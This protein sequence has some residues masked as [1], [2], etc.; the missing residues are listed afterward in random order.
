MENHIVNMENRNRTTIT[1][2]SDVESFDEEAITVILKSGAIYIKG[3]ELHIQKLDLQEGKVI[4]AGQVNSFAYS[5]KKEKQEKGFLK[6]ML[7]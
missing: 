7:K 2:V 3:K 4:I 1:E 5:D 6:K